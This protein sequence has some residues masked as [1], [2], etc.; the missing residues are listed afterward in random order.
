MKAFSIYPTAQMLQNKIDEYFDWCYTYEIKDGRRVP[1]VLIPPTF[2]GLARYLG[3]GSRAALLR[4][5][6]KENEAFEDVI[7][8]AKL[9]IEEFYEG[10]LVM[11]KGPSTGLQFALKNNCGWEDTT[12][13]QLTGADNKPLLFTWGIEEDQKII[14]AEIASSDTSLQIE[15]PIKQETN[16]EPTTIEVTPDA[17]TYDSKDDSDFATMGDLKFE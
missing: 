16:E 8:D 11:S 12:K 17:P 3:F 7:N 6:N 9:R 14:D 5:V 4:Y 15:A 2:S 13:Q 1:K 10:R